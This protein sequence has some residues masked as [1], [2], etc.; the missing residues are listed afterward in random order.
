M[1]LCQAR[2]SRS[3]KMLDHICSTSCVEGVLAVSSEAEEGFSQLIHI[4]F[5][6]TR[7]SFKL[8]EDRVACEKVEWGD[9]SEIFCFLW[10]VFNILDNAFV[11]SCCL[12][13]VSFV[14]RGVLLGVSSR[15]GNVWQQD[16]A[17]REVLLSSFEPWCQLLLISFINSCST[18]SLSVLQFCNLHNYDTSRYS[19][20]ELAFSTYSNRF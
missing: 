8:R 13:D 1:Y 18:S 9:P 12:D 15:V 4:I 20:S 14:R 6:L 10:E 3:R 16:N 17:V 2:C 11:W 5:S 19:I 7:M